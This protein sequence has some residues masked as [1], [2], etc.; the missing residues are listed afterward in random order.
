MKSSFPGLSVARHSLNPSILPLPEPGRR[1]QTRERGVSGRRGPPP[2]VA[3]PAR[4][5][6]GLAR[7]VLGRQPR[8]P[9]SSGRQR[10]GPFGLQ[11]L[12]NGSSPGGP[13]LNLHLTALGRGL[14]G[15]TGRPVAC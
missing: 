6:G 5:R 3:T 8:F 1:V 10:N 4:S 7:P 12:F 15:C 13:R 9:T 2:E 14:A 11:F